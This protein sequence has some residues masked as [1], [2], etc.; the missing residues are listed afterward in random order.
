MQYNLFCY[1]NVLSR[2]LMIMMEYHVIYE[3]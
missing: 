1:S 2:L 3:Y